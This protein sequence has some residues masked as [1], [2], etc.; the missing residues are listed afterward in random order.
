[1]GTMIIAG[2]SIGVIAF[3]AVF[4]VAMCKERRQ[5]KTG[6]FVRISDG[7]DIWVSPGTAE[8]DSSKAA[9]AR[10]ADEEESMAKAQVVTLSPKNDSP[11]G[12][13]F[14]HQQ[15]RLRTKVR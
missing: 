11:G 14:D 12:A 2:I 6:Y 15:I 7:E 13:P 5:M 9:A 3:M 4:F 8:Q 1:M 10:G